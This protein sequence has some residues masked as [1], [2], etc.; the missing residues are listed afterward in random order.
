MRYLLLTSGRRVR[1]RCIQ[2]P[3]RQFV[4]RKATA[5]KLM[6]KDPK[7]KINVDGEVP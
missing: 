6:P 1:W 5:V 3:D 7:D 4:I 2:Q